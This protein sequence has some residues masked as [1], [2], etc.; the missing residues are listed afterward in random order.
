[1]SVSIPPRGAITSQ[2]LV[3]TQEALSLVRGEVKDGKGGIMMEH[4]S[5]RGMKAR[6][7]ACS[8][9]QGIPVL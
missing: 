7:S 4:M 5:D 3:K 1:M 6:I 2:W 8:K 9:L